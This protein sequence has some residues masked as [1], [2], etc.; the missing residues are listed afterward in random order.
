MKTYQIM[1]T[2]VSETTGTKKLSE[3]FEA[4]DSTAAKKAAIK[5]ARAQYKHYLQCFVEGALIIDNSKI[6]RR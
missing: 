6:I 1:F 4:A 2:L 3:A 5:H